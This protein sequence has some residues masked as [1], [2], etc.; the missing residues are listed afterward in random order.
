MAVFAGLIHETNQI[1][2]FGQASQ[3]STGAGENLSLLPNRPTGRP[4]AGQRAFVSTAL[5]DVIVEV[6]R[7][8]RNPQLATLFENCYPNT[9]CRD[10]PVDS[11]RALTRSASLAR[12]L[13]TAQRP[14]QATCSAQET[15]NQDA[16]FGFRTLEI[17]STMKL[18]RS[19]T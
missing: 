5:E 9:C 4:A 8:I 19:E 14:K 12:A 18:S 11:R 3:A 6:N 15:C 10:A 7:K 2:A 17:F 16:N 13:P 1:D